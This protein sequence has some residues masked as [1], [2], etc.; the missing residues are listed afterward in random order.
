MMK[1]YIS[2]KMLTRFR[3]VELRMLAPYSSHKFLHERVLTEEF[4]ARTRRLRLL[5]D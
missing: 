1:A 2:R 4:L 5:E 3:V